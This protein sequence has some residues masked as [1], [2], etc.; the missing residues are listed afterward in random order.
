[1][2]QEMQY[3][4]PLQY[5]LWWLQVAFPWL[6]ITCQPTYVLSGKIAVL[7]LVT[8]QK[9]VSA[10]R[11]RKGCINWLNCDF[12]RSIH[13]LIVDEDT[14]QKGGLILEWQLLNMWE[15]VGGILWVEV[16]GLYLS[17]LNMRLYVL[18]SH[19]LDHVK[20]TWPIAL[21]STILW[22]GHLRNYWVGEPLF[23][24]RNISQCMQNDRTYHTGWHQLS[25]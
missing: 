8:L 12:A 11:S 13:E 4:H 19:T 23:T 2:L 3:L 15:K 25:L 21:T 5:L 20:I 7:G 9:K 16:V 6:L 18:D 14:Y 1:M 17:K 10:E 22:Q 24:V